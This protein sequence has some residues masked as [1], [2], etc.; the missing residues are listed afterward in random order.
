MLS[1]SILA[2]NKFATPVTMAEFFVLA[3]Y[4]V[5]QVLIVHNTRPVI[6]TSTSNP[7]ASVR[8]A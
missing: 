3:T 7:L 2:I 4:Y 6:A 1:D 8:A 5:A